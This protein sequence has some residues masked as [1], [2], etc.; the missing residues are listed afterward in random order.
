MIKDDTS[1]F[2]FCHRSFRIGQFRFFFQNLCDS[3]CTRH[4]HGYHN[5]YHGHHHQAHQNIHTISKKTHK[6]SGSQLIGYDHLCTK[7]ADSE[8]TAVYRKLHQRCIVRQDLFSFYKH[9][10]YIV[11]CFRKLFVFVI[12]SHIRFYH[13]DTGNIFLHTR[14]QIIIFFKYFLKIS[15]HPADD[16]EQACAKD[17]NCHQ[18]NTCQFCID[19]KGHNHR[20]DHADRRTHKHTKQ[21][22]VC[23]L[24]IGYI[25]GQSCDQS[26]GT[27]PVD[28]GK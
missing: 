25:R 4:T 5:K 2:Y 9:F 7:P 27:E 22:L 15:G 18:I 23:I 1:I 20:T 12:F 6:F 11:T 19:I 14:I 8:N 24:Y 10:I 26:G 3:F 28:I 16:K 21:H 13:T 17:N